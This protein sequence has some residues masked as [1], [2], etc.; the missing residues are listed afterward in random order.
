MTAYANPVCRHP[1]K[2]EQN[3]EPRNRR[4]QILTNKVKRTPLELYAATDP[5]AVRICRG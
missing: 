5:H 1:H 2:E 3:I 4:K